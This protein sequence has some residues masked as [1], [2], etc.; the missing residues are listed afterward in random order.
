[1]KKA[2][3]AVFMVLVVITASFGQANYPTKPITV[4]AGSNQPSIHGR[5][6]GIS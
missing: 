3:V 6:D 5:L 2:I 4:L 1:M